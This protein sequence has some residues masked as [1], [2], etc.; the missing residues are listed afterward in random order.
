MLDQPQFNI[1][2]WKQWSGVNYLDDL[3]FIGPF[4]DDGIF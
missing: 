1:Q 2:N 4:I 3:T